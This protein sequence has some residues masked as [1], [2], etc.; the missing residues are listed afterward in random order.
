VTAGFGDS[1]LN[2]GAWKAEA[3]RV[4]RRVDP[5][6]ALQVANQIANHFLPLAFTSAPVLT[7]SS[8]ALQG[9]TPGRRANIG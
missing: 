3:T 9:E 4:D 5:P 6:S 2:F 8:T 1:P 7:G